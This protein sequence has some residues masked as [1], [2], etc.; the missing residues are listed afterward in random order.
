MSLLCHLLPLCLLLLL[1]PRAHAEDPILHAALQSE[2]DLFTSS[3]DGGEQAQ[4]LSFFHPLAAVMLAGAPAFVGLQNISYVIQVTVPTITLFSFK[5]VEA[6]YLHRDASGA[7]GEYAYTLANI[8]SSA[9]STVGVSEALLV[10]TRAATAGGWQI[11]IFASVPRPPHNTTTTA[12]APDA[13]ESALKGA[14]GDNKESTHPVF[15]DARHPAVRAALPQSLLATATA[16]APYDDG[17]ARVKDDGVRAL[18]S[19]I[20]SKISQAFASGNATL[21]ASYYGERFRGFSEGGRVD[22][23]AALAA[24]F[25]S[26]MKA[27]ITSISSTL[28][29]AGYVLA[30]TMLFERSTYTI[31]T[32]TGKVVDVGKTLSIW[33]NDASGTLAYL[34]L[35]TSNL[36]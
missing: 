33:R 26:L 7:G 22:G 18:L 4:V 34:A 13:A 14:R 2:L 5:V 6:D 20:E 8:T 19:N 25:A 12:S 24:V 30:D 23:Q 11:Y 35:S 16:A 10:W 15:M 21:A 27:G 9:N 28:D 3:W 29:D 31:S 32:A 17:A 36:H 1:P